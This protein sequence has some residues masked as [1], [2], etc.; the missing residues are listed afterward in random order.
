MAYNVIV[1]VPAIEEIARLRAFEQRQIIAAIE[2]Q[3]THE[4]T[5]ETRRR[6][7]L[8]GLIPRF[9]HVLPIWEL[10]VGNY[11]VFFDVDQAAN[12]VH[13]RAVREKKSEQRTEDIT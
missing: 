10:R 2:E 1:H 6:K 12:E 7:C 11:R 9:A 3:L 13:V 5:K 4:P 8:V